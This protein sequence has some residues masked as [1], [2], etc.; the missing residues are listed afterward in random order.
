MCLMCCELWRKTGQRGPFDHQLQEDQKKDTDR[1]ITPAAEA[2][3]VLN[4]WCH[5]GLHKPSSCATFTFNSHWGRDVTGKK[6]LLSMHAGSRWS[7]PTL[8]DAVDCHLPGFSVRGILWAR[9]LECI[10][11][12]W[13]PYLSRTLYFL[14]P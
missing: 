3:G 6:I 4:T 10:G 11:Q 12:Y 1:A 7:C 13:L 5:K 9:I 14:L 8:C 2:V